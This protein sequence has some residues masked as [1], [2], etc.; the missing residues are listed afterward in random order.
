M[1]YPE[2]LMISTIAFMT[3]VTII[4]FMILTFRLIKRN[5]KK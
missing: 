2:A 5:E 3:G 1:D 4:T